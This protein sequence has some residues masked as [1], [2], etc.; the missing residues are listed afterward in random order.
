MSDDRLAA[1]EAR[2]AALEAAAASQVA[3]TADPSEGLPTSS[4]LAHQLADQLGGRDAIGFFGA[5]TTQRGPVGWSW[6]RTQDWLTDQDWRLAADRLD[7]L[8][9]PVRLE[10]LRLIMAGTDTTAGLAADEALGSTGQLHHH[11]RILIAAGWVEHQ[12][13]GRYAIP[14][15]RAVPL[16]VVLTIALPSS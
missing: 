4:E 1:L 2:V 10:L 3:A 13:R 8:A 11:L 16:A 14:P 12:G 6:A 5:L 15:A 7:A 9:N